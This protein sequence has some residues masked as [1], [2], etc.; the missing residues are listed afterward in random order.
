MLSNAT[1]INRF[2]ARSGRKFKLIEGAFSFKDKREIDNILAKY[3]SDKKQ[4]ATL[5]LLHL[6]QKENGFINSGVINAVSKIVGTKPAKVQETASFYSMFRFEPP[7]KH[8]IEVC[9]GVPCYLR[10][11]E[12]IK[13]VIEQETGG[14]FASGKSADGLFT[15]EEVECLGACANAPVM[16]VDGVYYQNLTGDIVKKIVAGLK[17][18]SDISRYDAMHTPPAKP[19]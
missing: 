7:N 3:P 16:V 12:N 19:L 8:I 17:S 15:L 11:S 2:F 9:K 6:G 18:G 1:I 10:K 4:S 14:T 5:P 13:K